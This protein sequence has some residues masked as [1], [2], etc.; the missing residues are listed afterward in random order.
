MM[1]LAVPIIYFSYY[2][3]QYRKFLLSKHTIFIS[4]LWIMSVVVIGKSLKFTPILA[5]FFIGICAY[6]M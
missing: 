3:F 1:A 6:I 5:I 2:Y 4:S